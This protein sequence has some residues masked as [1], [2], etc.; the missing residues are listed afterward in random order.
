ME[1]GWEVLGACVGDSGCCRRA[2]VVFL[3]PDVLLWFFGGRKPLSEVLTY[4][5][6]IAGGI[7]L[8]GNL[9][10]TERRNRLTDANNRLI[11]KNTRLMEKGQLDTRF[12]DA[13]M[14]LGNDST[15]L[16]GIYALNQVGIDASSIASQK[17]YAR[18]V[19]EILCGIIRENSDPD[20]RKKP[21]I[22]FQTIV[23][24][25]FRNDSWETYKD[26]ETDLCESNLRGIS[27]SRVHLEGADLY[28]VHLEGANL[29]GAHLEKAN[30]YKAHLEGV[31]LNEAHLEK[32]C[33]CEAHLEG[34][35]LMKAYLEG[36]D[37]RWAHLEG[38]ILID[39]HLEGAYVS[40]TILDKAP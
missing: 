34:A 20:V 3:F 40:G 11:E 12:K 29:R 28:D 24:V 38:A 7:I 6:V 37:L 4:L 36:V 39:A 30:L 27:L 13:A 23:D 10:A 14:L 32:A 8:L 21:A 5:G 18:V 25:L 17:D 1:K 31:V 15:M 9:L 26:Y 19:K 16:A 22:V 2:G 33:L 35:N